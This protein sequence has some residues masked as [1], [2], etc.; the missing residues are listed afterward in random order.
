[1]RNQDQIAAL[2]RTAEEAEAGGLSVLPVRVD[3]SK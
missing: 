3:G 1:M 2:K